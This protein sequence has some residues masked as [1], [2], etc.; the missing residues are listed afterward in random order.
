MIYFS[1]PRTI[2]SNTLGATKEMGGVAE[3][4]VEKEPIGGKGRAYGRIPSP[5]LEVSE[6]ESEETADPAAAPTHRVIGFRDE[7]FNGQAPVLAEIGVLPRGHAMGTGKETDAGDLTSARTSKSS[8]TL[9]DAEGADRFRN[10]ENDSD[11]LC[12]MWIGFRRA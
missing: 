2:P 3:D 9:A 8:Q 10:F 5:V 7:I 1:H 6:H 11:A 4:V 12:L